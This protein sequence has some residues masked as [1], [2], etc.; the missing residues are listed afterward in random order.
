MKNF[1]IIVTGGQ[2]N[3]TALNREDALNKLDESERPWV[4][5]VVEVE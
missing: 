2:H 4:L 1:L 3:V 5:D